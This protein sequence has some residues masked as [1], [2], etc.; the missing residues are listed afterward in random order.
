MSHRSGE[1]PDETI[2]HLAVAFGTPIIKTG[3]VGGERIAKLNE[4][5]RMEELGGKMA[6]LA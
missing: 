1:T 2:A 3:I 6:E 5:I 4:L